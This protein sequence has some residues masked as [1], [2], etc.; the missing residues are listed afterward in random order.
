VSGLLPGL[1]I[2]RI[3]ARVTVDVDL[4]VMKQYWLKRDNEPINRN[5]IV[6]RFAW[7]FDFCSWPANVTAF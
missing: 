2:T 6:K 3:I 7:N 1:N 5:Q 4:H